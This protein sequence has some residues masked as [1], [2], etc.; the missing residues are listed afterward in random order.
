MKSMLFLANRLHNLLTAVNH[1]L[2]VVNPADPAERSHSAQ[3]PRLK[4]CRAKS[5]RSEAEAQILQSEVTALR[6]EP[7]INL[8]SSAAHHNEL[9]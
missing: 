4:S 3:K 9:F 5:Q 1:L 8:P 2:T 6:S 7:C